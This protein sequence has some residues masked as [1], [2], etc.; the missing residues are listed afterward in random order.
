MSV[1]NWNS[2]SYSVSWRSGV[3]SVPWGRVSVRRGGGD[4][5]DLQ[6]T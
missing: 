6:T 2:S 4:D 3:W 5:G 1:R